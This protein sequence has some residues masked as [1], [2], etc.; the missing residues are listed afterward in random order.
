MKTRRIHRFAQRHG[1]GG[2][3]INDLINRAGDATPARA[4]ES[5]DGV[6]IARANARAHVVQ[7]TLARSWR[8]GMPGVRVKSRHP[9]TERYTEA[10]CGDLRAESASLGD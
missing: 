1:T 6:R 2:K 3:M 9:M 5:E 7:R 4:A 8:V 10:T